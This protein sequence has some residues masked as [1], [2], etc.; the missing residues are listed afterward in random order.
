MFRD[1]SPEHVALFDKLRFRITGK[2]D[3]TAAH[4]MNDRTQFLFE[5][6]DQITRTQ[7]WSG[8]VYYSPDLLWVT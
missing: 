1:T 4:A 5:D 6:P 8:R 7:L 3:G 2:K